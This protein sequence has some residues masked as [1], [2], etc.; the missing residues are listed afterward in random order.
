MGPRKGGGIF[1]GNVLFGGGGFGLVHV[2]EGRGG[3]GD[4]FWLGA[5]LTACG[6][7]D[8][9]DDGRRELRGLEGRGGG[10][11]GRSA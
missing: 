6:G 9:V 2:A 7:D 5:S 10:R 8:P 11:E 4:R 3:K 1:F